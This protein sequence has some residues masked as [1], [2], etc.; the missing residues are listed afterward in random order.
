MPADL[1]C[2]SQGEGMR[3]SL[4]VTVSVAIA[5]LLSSCSKRT[6]FQAGVP[7]EPHDPDLAVPA[8]GYHG[9][10][11]R[12]PVYI[13]RVSPIADGTTTYSV[14]YQDGVTVLSKEE[15]RRHLLG[16][17]RDGTYI[18][19]ASAAQIA[20]LQPGSVLLLSGLALCTVDS[21]EKSG[22]RYLLKT[23]PAKITDAIRQGR[24]EGVYKIDFARMKG[25]GVADFDVNFGGYNYHVRFTPGDDRIRVQ[26]SIKFAGNQGAL[27]YEGVGYLSNFVSRLRM[28]I[29]DGQVEKLSFA[30]SALGGQVELKWFAVANSAMKTGSVAEITS[31]PAELL[32]SAAL[33]R[34]AYHVPILIG[35]VPFDLRISLGFSFIPAF[36]SKNSLVEGSKLITYSGSGGFILA[37]GAT[38]PTGS[39]DVHADVNERDSQVIAAGP[40]GFTAATE[41]P[42]I[43][44][45]LGWPPNPLPVAGYLNF[46]TSYGIVTNGMAS[47]TPCQTNIMAFSANAG[48]AYTSPDTFAKWLPM[49]GSPVPLWQKTYK[50]GG[51]TGKMC[52]AE[53][54]R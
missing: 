43:D 24:L 45:A 46:V 25:R 41:A 5:L 15:T 34:A 9:N 14:T 32:K 49:G 31:W 19:D 12:G 7:G 4:S 37:D 51:A 20:D 27:A 11:F 36:T 10:H 29:N 22:D 13:P 26:A 47:Q 17:Q 18:F 30:N 40:V 1:A 42:R 35:P 8:G 53:L 52:P 44:L 23:A 38:R 33:S 39:L 28:E 2:R 21:V 3:T 50:S 6:A 16:I 48:P 54:G